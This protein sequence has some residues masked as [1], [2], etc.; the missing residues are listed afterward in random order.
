MKRPLS[1][2][3]IAWVLI[4]FSLIGVVSIFMIGSN[5]EAM[6]MMEQMPVSI[7]FQKAWTVV[8]TI[9]NL[10]IAYGIFKGQPWSRVLYAVWGIIGAIAGFY[11]S[12]MKVTAMVG[13]IVFIVVCAFLFTNRA[14]EWFSARGLALKRES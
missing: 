3:I 11:I 9:I 2:T 13:L 4:V 14:N 5:P 6:K 1:L 8:G 12:P 10:A 7:E